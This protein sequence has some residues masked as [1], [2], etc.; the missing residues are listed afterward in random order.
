MPTSPAAL[1]REANKSLPRLNYYRIAPNGIFDGIPYFWF[2]PK[3][4]PS[5]SVRYMDL[6]SLTCEE[7]GQ[8]LGGN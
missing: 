6:E 3:E 4:T 8:E 2:A 7:I 5:P 1:A